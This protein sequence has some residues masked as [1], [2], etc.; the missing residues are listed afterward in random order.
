MP[1]G[2]PQTFSVCGSTPA[3]P[4]ITTTAPS[5]TRSERSTSTVKSA[6]PGVS[7]RVSVWPFH[8]QV[9]AAAPMVMPRLRSSGSKSVVVVP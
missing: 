8:E 9:T 5:R 6:W 1:V 3:T 7:T 4:S 2:L